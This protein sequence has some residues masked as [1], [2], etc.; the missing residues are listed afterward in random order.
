MILRAAP[1]NL[2]TEHPP[3]H[4]LPLI[5]TTTHPHPPPTPTPHSLAPHPSRLTPS[6]DLQTHPS[7]AEPIPHPP[8]DGARRH[9][10]RRR[11]HRI[12]WEQG[13]RGRERESEREGEDGPRIV[14]VRGRRSSNSVCHERH[15]YTIGQRT[16]RVKDSR[17]NNTNQ[18]LVYKPSVGNLTA[19]NITACH[20][21]CR[22]ISQAARLPTCPSTCRA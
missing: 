3:L 22:R 21:P 7:H 13:D 1:P 14:I 12:A 15:A 2:S 20:P 18:H 5:T 9:S 4:P 10:L 16:A 19:T 17:A 6:D 11:R 8:V